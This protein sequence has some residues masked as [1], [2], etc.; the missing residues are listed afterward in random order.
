M[1]KSGYNQFWLSIP[2]LTI[3][4]LV[5]FAFGLFLT[6]L[7]RYP[8]GLGADGLGLHIRLFAV[9]DLIWLAL[10]YGFGL[11]DF[12][13]HKHP[14]ELMRALIGA[15]II[16]FVLAALF[17]YIQPSLIITPRR[18]LLVDTAIV[19]LLTTAWQFFIR[20]ITQH[21]LRETVYFIDLD[22]VYEAN[23]SEFDSYSQWSIHPIHQ[24]DLSSLE[25]KRLLK[26]SSPIFV[27]PTNPTF[28]QETISI[29]ARLHAQGATFVPFTDYYESTFRRVYTANLNDWWLLE[30]THQNTHGFYPIIKRWL[31][32]IGAIGIG[33]IFFLTLLPIA[34]LIK[35]SDRGSIFFTQIRLSINGK[36]FTI[37]KYRT[38][39]NGTPNN[40][41]TA[42]HD[43]RVTAVGRFLRTTRLDELPQWINILRGDMS[44]VG[45]RPEQAGMV[46]QIKQDVPFFESRHMV[47]P[48]LIG[49]AQLH[50]YAG[51]ATET[52]RKLQ[53]DLYYLK[54]QS[55]LF[56]VE[57]F[58]KTIAHVFFLN[59]K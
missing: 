29:L 24:S 58:L 27:V 21:T 23:K 7:W 56:D 11:L 30:N 17:F 6:L 40:T 15:H 41:W 38:M 36:P 16:G 59:G 19:F 4:T 13:A 14:S 48:G 44:L 52:K 25:Q 37:F 51:N 9:I 35:L 57:I 43:P 53:Y 22:E 54:H 2:L 45:P 5:I 12:R 1:K 26:R 49:W 46:E 10:Y 20:L 42:D 31:D 28:S 50:V 34:I 55:F 3:P 32:V 18:V 39:R 47:R 8:Q 33:S